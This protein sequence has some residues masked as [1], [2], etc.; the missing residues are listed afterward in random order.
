MY[1]YGINSNGAC[2]A[3]KPN[4]AVRRVANGNRSTAGAITDLYCLLTWG[5]IFGALVLTRDRVTQDQGD[6]VEIGRRESD[7]SIGGVR[8]EHEAIDA[9]SELT[10]IEI[11]RMDP[12]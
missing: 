4:P 7:R 3:S 1:G 9:L 6:A 5:R 2:L 12:Q 10:T 8:S 11:E